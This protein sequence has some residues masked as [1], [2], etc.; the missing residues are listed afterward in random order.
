MGRQLYET[1]FCAWTQEQAAILRGTT[2]GT[3]DVDHLAEELDSM[4]R[5]EDKKV[6]SLLRQALIH[7]LKIAIM[8]EHCDMPHWIEEIVTFQGDAALEYSQSQRKR[9]EFDKIWRVSCNGIRQILPSYGA[10]VPDLPDESPLSLD[11]LVAEDFNVRAAVDRI[12][13]ALR[14]APLPN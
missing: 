9:L 1:D 8:P 14:Q 4:G 11:D 12:S 7:L 3:I 13:A 10:E 2:P 6:A 5:S